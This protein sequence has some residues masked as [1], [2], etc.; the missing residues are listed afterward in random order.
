MNS[1]WTVTLLTVIYL[2]LYVGEI[3]GKCDKCRTVVRVGQRVFPGSFVSHSHVNDQCYDL[4]K[5]EECWEY[6][7]PYYQVYNKGYSRG[8]G[9]GIYGGVSRC[10][11]NDRWLCIN[12]GGQWDIPS[13]L[14]KEHVDKVK[15][16]IIQDE[17]KKEVEESK[18]RKKTVI[19]TDPSIYQEIEKDIVLPDVKEN[20]FIDLATRI[21]T[22][23]NI[24]GCWVCGGLH[25]SE[26]WPWR[27]ESLSVWELLERNWTNVPDRKEQ[28]WKLTN[29][30]EGQ[31]CVERK[32]KVKVGESPCQSIKLAKREG[33]ITWWP[34]EPTWYI[35]REPYGSCEAIGNSSNLWNCSGTNPSEGV[36]RV[37]EVWK[38]AKKG[39]FAPEGLFWICG[40]Q[41]Y[42][43]LPLDWAGVCFLG[44]IRPEF[45]LLPQEDDQ[46]LGIK[47]FD[48]LRREKREIKMGE[49]GDKW[50]PARIIKYYGPATW[51]Q[52]GSWGYRTPIYMLNRIIRLQAVVEVITNQTA[53]ALELLAKQQS[54]MRTAIYQNRLAVDYLL[55]SEGGVC[56][57]FNL[58]NCCLKIDD[59]GKAVLKISDKIWK[60]AHVPVQ[61]WRSLGN[62][63]WLDGLLGGSWW[64]TALLVAGGGLMILLLLPC[65]IPCIRTLI[66]RSIFQLQ[67]VAI[68]QHGTNELKLMLLKKKVDPPRGAEEGR[69]APW[70]EEKC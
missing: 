53:L 23:L 38:E 46:K 51:A 4:S 63:S 64:R 10:P 30:P 3:E 33:N 43:K 44:L 18:Q 5:R 15:E 19:S 45:F 54:Q 9:W 66:R 58:T 48:S 17:K 16:T 35:T 70:K 61:T 36:P 32:G 13:T 2:I 37:R 57:K 34:E 41:A 25:M 69:W 67:A 24:S 52:D 26:Q 29:Y 27:G 7:K 49:W 20:L 8:Y 47:L 21:A 6:S 28:K 31:A 40:N 56:G 1:M 12:K 68:P 22:S 55:A 39:G 62:M 65:V 59:S 50:P 42:T 11:R 60:L 14:V